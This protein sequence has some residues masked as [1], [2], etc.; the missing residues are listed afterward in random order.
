MGCNL[1]QLTLRTKATNGRRSPLCGT[2]TH[3]SGMHRPMSAHSVR[4]KAPPTVGGAF[5]RD[6]RT[7]EASHRL[8]AHDLWNLFLQHPLDTVR[9]GQLRHR[10]AA[11]GTLQSNLNHAILCHFDQL[12]VSSVGLQGRTDL[13]ERSLDTFLHEGSPS[14][15]SG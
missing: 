7:R 6:V 12:D 3:A 1:Q 2:T 8:D 15:A 11:A 5:F 10:A 13:V 14:I 9:E 4:K